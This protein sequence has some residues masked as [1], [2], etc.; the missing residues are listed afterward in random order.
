MSLIGPRRPDFQRL[1]YSNRCMDQQESRTHTQS[2]LRIQTGDSGVSSRADRIQPITQPPAAV[3]PA[4]EEILQSSIRAGSIAQVV[5]AAVAVIGL[6]Y[7][8]KLV[9]ITTLTGILLAFIL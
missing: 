7:L 8:L 1:Q 9:M 4:E 3:A 6:I 2:D 5:V